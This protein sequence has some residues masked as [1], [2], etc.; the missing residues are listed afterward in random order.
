MALRIGKSGAL[1]LWVR[2]WKGYL[3][4]DLTSCRLSFA[5]QRFS[6]CK[7]P[8]KLPREQFTLSVVTTVCLCAWVT[9]SLLI[10][11]RPSRWWLLQSRQ[12]LHHDTDSGNLVMHH[13]INS[14]RVTRLCKSH[15]CE[16]YILSDSDSTWSVLYH[17][18]LLVRYRFPILSPLIHLKKGVVCT[19]TIL[20]FNS[21]LVHSTW[22]LDCWAGQPI[23]F[24]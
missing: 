20:K 22:A 7:P 2:M 5:S 8:S 21:N 13:C 3:K 11:I 17:S 10:V 23:L 6:W 15:S 1:F 18:Y 19:N 9:T 14:P 24:A 12:Q 4:R 16:C